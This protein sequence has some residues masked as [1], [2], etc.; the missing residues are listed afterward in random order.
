MA[1][2]GISLVNLI[3]YLEQ[4]LPA[5]AFVPTWFCV[6]SGIRAP[7]SYVSPLIRVDSNMVEC[8]DVDILTD[9]L[10]VIDRCDVA[11]EV[12]L[13]LAPIA[14][15]HGC[16]FATAK[17]AS[18][19]YRRSDLDCPNFT[20]LYPVTFTGVSSDRDGNT[21]IDFARFAKGPSTWKRVQ[22]S[23]WEEYPCEDVFMRGRSKKNYKNTPRANQ[24]ALGIALAKL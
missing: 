3:R 16:V 18:V 5:Y 17:V 6:T 4:F 19:V 8:I 23:S 12:A 21:W 11:P 7:R 9:T 24:C 10:Q 14:F 2:T 20:N 13:K 22:I 1:R 15:W